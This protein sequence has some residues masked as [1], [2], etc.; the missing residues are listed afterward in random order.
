MGLNRRPTFMPSWAALMA[1][2]YPPGPDPITTRSLS[3]GTNNQPSQKLVA[4][5]K[6]S[7][8]CKEMSLNYHN[9]AFIMY[10]QYSQCVLHIPCK[11]G[12]STDFYTVPGFAVL[13]TLYDKTW[14]Y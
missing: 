2:T 8:F 12:V 1:A 3:P 6:F 11:K 10:L 9:E 5:I 7:S 4:L 13:F 14:V